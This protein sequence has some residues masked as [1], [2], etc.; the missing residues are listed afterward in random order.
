M[1]REHP[2]VEVIFRALVPGKAGPT[3]ATISAEGSQRIEAE[4]RR[5]IAEG[6]IVRCC[7]EALVI[8]GYFSSREETKE[9]FEEL[10]RLRGK[11]WPEIEVA[12]RAQAEQAENVR[13]DHVVKR[14]EMWGARAPVGTVK[15]H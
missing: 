10:Q 7:E 1:D 14:A 4:V 2:I 9:A 11:L 5:S 13:G 12:L 6:E 3:S 15:H 8:I